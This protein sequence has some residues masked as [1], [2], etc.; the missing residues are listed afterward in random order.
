MIVPE[1]AKKPW[2]IRLDKPIGHRN[3]TMYDKDKTN[4]NKI[5]SLFYEVFCSWLAS[6]GKW[7]NVGPVIAITRTQ[8]IGL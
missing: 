5:L 1:S 6:Q 3:L 8:Q 2:R 4:F 7:I